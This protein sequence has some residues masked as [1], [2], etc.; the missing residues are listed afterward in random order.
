MCFLDY[1]DRSKNWIPRER[2]Q[3]RSQNQDQRQI[4][5]QVQGD[6]IRSPIRFKNQNTCQRRVQD[7]AKHGN[8]SPV[9]GAS[10]NQRL[11]Y[12]V[13]RTSKYFHLDIYV[14]VFRVNAAH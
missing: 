7:A 13:G 1:G 2:D 14:F 5:G 4:R 3:R 9:H 6:P 8:R 12:D 10:H 11:S